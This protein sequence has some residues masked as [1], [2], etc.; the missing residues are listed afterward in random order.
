[1]R[2]NDQIRAREV[3]VI[4]EEGEQI[5][6]VPLV[7]ALRMARERNVDLVEVA[8]G[9]VP[10]VV[11]L[12]DYGR[13]K[14]EQTR[15]EREARKHQKTV[16]IKEVRLTPKTDEHDLDFKTRA[17]QRF[18]EEGDKVKVSIRFKGR[19]M[20]HPQLG[21]QL[22]DDIAKKLESTAAIERTPVMEGRIMSIILSK[23]SASPKRKVPETGE[24]VT[25]SKAV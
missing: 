22:L 10:P 11:R 4:G 15:K 7:E 6:V 3:R 12:M 20:A 5:G 25:S 21:R 19:E 14:Y 17:I 8:P 18:L 9:A 24:Q 16:L 23:G 2:I 13:F 1:M